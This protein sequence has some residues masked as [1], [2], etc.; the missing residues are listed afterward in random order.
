MHLR[1]FIEPQQGASYDDQARVARES[2]T[3]GFDAF[4]RSDHLVRI[5][6]GDPMPGPT[7][8]WVT[9]GAIAR[10]TS[11]IHLGTLVTSATFRPPGL[12]AVQVAQVDAMSN[13]RVE[14]GLGTGWFDDEHHAYGIGFPP[15]GERFDR[16]AEQ[17]EIVTEIWKTPPGERYSFRGRHYRLDD[18][19]ALPQPVQTPPPLIIG[20]VGAR[21]TPELAARFADEFNIPF[22]PLEFVG[23]AY[24]NVD[25]ACEAAGRDSSDVRRSVAL[26]SCVGSDDAEIARRADAI[27]RDPAELR[28]NALAGTPGEVVDRLGDFAAAGVERVYLQILDLSD[29][30][31]LRL[32]ADEV[33]APAT[34]L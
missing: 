3:L 17:L 8:S 15:L 32:I 11:T 24:G 25:R 9:L 13:G 1:I 16:L 31:H 23:E 29:L 14:L 2:E 4:F 19:P 34:E 27:E 21:R 7:D 20:G 10:E 22:P 6:E 18:C 30:D 33:L 5:G 28:E 26:V 12:L